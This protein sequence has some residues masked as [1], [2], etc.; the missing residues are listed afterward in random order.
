M[1]STGNLGG[2]QKNKKNFTPQLPA[3]QMVIS[4][5]NGTVLRKV[6]SSQTN[7]KAQS[8]SS[9]NLNSAEFSYNSDFAFSPIPN[10]SNAQGIKSYPGKMCTS[11]PSFKPVGGPLT[12]SNGVVKVH[13]QSGLNSRIPTENDAGLNGSINKQS[14]LQKNSQ[15]PLKKRPDSSIIVKKILNTG[16]KQQATAQVKPKEADKRSL[17]AAQGDESNYSFDSKKSRKEIS[18]KTS[19]MYGSDANFLNLSSEVFDASGMSS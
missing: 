17:E 10:R 1:F 11:T 2:F 4:L 18:D 3:K 7:A 8:R 19:M 9:L 14:P 6:L 12:A 16:M 13:P 15:L 5:P